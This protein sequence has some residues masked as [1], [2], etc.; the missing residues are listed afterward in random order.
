MR[1]IHWSEVVPQNF[2]KSPCLEMLSKSGHISVQTAGA[3][4]SRVPYELREQVN[5]VYDS[6]YACAYFNNAFIKLGIKPLS[7]EQ[8]LAAFKN[9]S[10]PL[11]KAISQPDE[12]DE[13]KQFYQSIHDELSTFAALLPST[14]NNSRNANDYPVRWYHAIRLLQRLE[15]LCNIEFTPRKLSKEEAKKR[16]SRMQSHA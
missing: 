4:N 11:T 1:T 6:S 2:L 8:Y 3:R 15:S 14:G 9:C 16:L 13:Y 5:V 7:D 12:N 10:N